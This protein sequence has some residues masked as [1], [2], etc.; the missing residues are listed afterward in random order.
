MK[1]AYNSARYT[2]TSQQMVVIIIIITK[3]KQALKIIN[4]ILV[5]SKLLNIS[6]MK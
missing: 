3:T 1:N 5:S 4:N 2:A 6:M